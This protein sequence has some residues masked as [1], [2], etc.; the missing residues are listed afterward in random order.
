MRCGSA[1]PRQDISHNRERAEAV[2]RQQDLH[3]ELLQNEM[4]PM[5]HLQAAASI[6]QAWRPVKV[7]SNVDKWKLQFYAPEYASATRFNVLVLEGDA[8]FGKNAVCLL[9]LWPA[10]HVRLQLARS[11]SA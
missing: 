6:G 4:I 11:D 3:A 5:H 8:R 2:L 7:I 9:P 1:T 10:A